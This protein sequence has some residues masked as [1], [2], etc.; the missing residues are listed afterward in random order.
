MRETVGRS[1]GVRICKVRGLNVFSRAALLWALLALPANAQQNL[2]H[3]LWVWKGPSVAQEPQG[4]E[5]LRDF[6]RSHHINEIYISVT[7][8]GQP[9]PQ[10]PLADLIAV[11]H[12]SGIRVEA[13]LSSEKADEAGK[14]RE[15]LLDKVHEVLAFNHD[16]RRR[17][18]DGIHLDI[19]PQ[20]RPEN[21]G[22]GNLRF[23]PGLVAAYRDVRAAAEPAHLTVNA[24]IQN[25]LLK[26]DPTERRMLMTSL[27]RL[28]LMLYEVSAPEDPQSA[29][30]LR[31]A[32]AKFLDMAYAGLSDSHLATMVIGIRTPDYGAQMPA[33]VRLLD[34]AN[35]SNPHY[36]GW[37]WHAYGD[38][39]AAP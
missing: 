12:R 19:E 2:V 39:A 3:G 4:A 36:A 37:S 24:D 26:G 10:R 31:A 28:T 9:M 32:S 11:L 35:T 20:Q 16:H 23:L 6:C 17:Q 13:L 22:A 14:H 33:M 30:K 7:E 38:S 27:P 1:G 8:H 21:K 25:K 29:E 18:F 5:R 15:K 34:E